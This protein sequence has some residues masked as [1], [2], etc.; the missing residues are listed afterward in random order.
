ML[1]VDAG[2]GPIQC[3]GV[4][5][6]NFL[7]LGRAVRTRTDPA[8]YAAPGSGAM[9]QPMRRTPS[10][11]ANVGGQNGEETPR[12]ERPADL[13]WRR[14]D[15]SRHLRSQARR[16]PGDSGQVRHDCRPGL[17]GVRFSSMMPEMAKITDIYALCRSQ[18]TGSDHHETAAQWMLTGNYGVMQGGDYPGH[19]QQSSR[20]KPPPLIRSHRMWPCRKTTLLPGNWAKR[21]FWA[22]GTSRSSPAMWAMRS[23]RF[24]TCPSWPMCRRNA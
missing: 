15:P 9:R 13:S 24:P 6:R 20:M 23:G 7:R 16:A 4:S 1:D 3:D 10:S 19:W 12:Q 11:A 2:R 21:R 14:P 8:R 22:N 18:V 5:R 17:S